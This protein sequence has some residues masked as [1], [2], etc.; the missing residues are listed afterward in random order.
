MKKQNILTIAL[1]VMALSLLTACGV[2]KSNELVNNSNSIDIKSQPTLASC[3]RSTSAD[4]SFN[5]ANVIESTTGETNP[6]WIKIKFDFLSTDVT[7]SGYTVK[8]FKWRIIGT[9]AQLDSNPLSFNA[10]TISNGQTASETMTSVYAAQINQQYGFYINLN[11]D[12]QY[13]YQVLKVVIYKTDGTIAAQS[14][15]LIPQFLAN[16]NDYKT[17][18][19]GTVRADNLQ[20]LHPLYAT[21]VTAWT[22]AQ[23]KQNFD[24]YCF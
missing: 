23:L 24:Q 8:F 5:L 19:D 2:Q 20:K 9:S 21:D 7:K 18:S 13:P 3:N 15:V 22:Q 16:P 1:S 14:D 10:Y 17:N 12:T 11:D 4:L 6:N